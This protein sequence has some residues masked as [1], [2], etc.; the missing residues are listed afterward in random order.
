MLSL[1][2]CSNLHFM[3]SL[4]TKIPSE[5]LSPLFSSLNLLEC[6]AG[7]ML[8]LRGGKGLHLLAHGQV[9]YLCKDSEDEEI[10]IGTGYPGY[11]VYPEYFM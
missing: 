1:F 2:E 10:R 4:V 8:P 7:E 11:I 5:D 9:I 6:L 3:T